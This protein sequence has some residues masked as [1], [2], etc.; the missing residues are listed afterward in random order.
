MEKR[1]DAF[2]N[3]EVDSSV[4]AAAKRACDARRGR[5]A[6]A[7]RTAQGLPFY[8]SRLHG[9]H[10]SA[11]PPSH[12]APRPSRAAPLRSTPDRTSSSAANAASSA[13]QMLVHTRRAQVLRR[14]RP[15][16]TRSSSVKKNRPSVDEIVE[17][18]RARLQQ[19][20]HGEKPRVPIAEIARRSTARAAS[21]DGFSRA[22][23]LVRR[24][25]HQVLLVEPVELLGVEDRVA[26]ADAL[27]RERRDELVAREHLP[28]VAR[29]TSRAAPGS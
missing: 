28:I 25:P 4:D 16:R 5:A 17:P 11:S 10:E 9:R 23:E 3:A 29:A 22:R 8:P 7:L 18:L 14:P 24:E 2:R 13:A 19:L 15:R 26:A 21:N 6:R 12:L 27:E 20:E 1:T